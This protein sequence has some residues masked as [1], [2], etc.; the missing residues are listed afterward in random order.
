MS[1]LEQSQ[2]YKEKYMEL[3]GAGLVINKS[4]NKSKKTIH[5]PSTDAQ[6]ELRREQIKKQND[7][8]IV[9]IV[10]NFKMDPLQEPFDIYHALMSLSIVT[11]N[12][13]VGKIKTQL[14]KYLQSDQE[15]SDREKQIIKKILKEIDNC[16]KKLLWIKDECVTS[17]KDVKKTYNNI[18]HIKQL[19]LFH[20]ISDLEK[21]LK[22]SLNNPNVNT[23]LDTNLILQTFRFYLW[24][25]PDINKKKNK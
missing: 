20:T 21:Q 10:K 4:K 7:A 19:K 13:S 15:I 2:M 9:I 14:N 17:F 16:K 25:Y 11:E 24:A 6:I 3:K 23:D 1:Y 8:N 5:K 18:V 12:M 22:L